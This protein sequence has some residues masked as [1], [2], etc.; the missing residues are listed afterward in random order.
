MRRGW[1][2]GTG[3]V[4]DVFESEPAET[5]AVHETGSWWKGHMILVQVVFAPGFFVMAATSKST[6]SVAMILCG[7]AALGMQCKRRLYTSTWL[8][9]DRFV[10]V[11]GAVLVWL[12]RMLR[13][14]R[15]RWK[16][17]AENII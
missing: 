3:E 12:R 15:R 1:M 14:Q 5:T 4:H 7:S 6:F 16:G 9:A 2:V 10:D 8:A 13:T 17:D 11:T